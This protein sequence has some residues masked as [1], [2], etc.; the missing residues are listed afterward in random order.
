MKYGGL[1][2]TK[3][4]LLGIELELQEPAAIYVVLWVL[5]AYFLVRYYQYFRQE[6]VMALQVNLNHLGTV[7]CMPV[8]RS[9]VE[10]RHAKVV[11]SGDI[12]DPNRPVEYDALGRES[13]WWREYKGLNFVP[14]GIGGH[15]GEP[16]VEL[17]SL[18][19][20]RRPLAKVWYVFIMNTSGVTDYIL[21][22]GV[23]LGVLVYA[24]VGGWEGGL[25]AIIS[26]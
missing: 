11:F 22:W 23:A 17:I 18:W 12:A 21:P 6:A 2:V 8:V 20:L 19:D 5:W 4:R 10:A 14:D 1:T 15:R 9:I 13:W 16:I 24:N 7:Y 26:R 25:A 3:A